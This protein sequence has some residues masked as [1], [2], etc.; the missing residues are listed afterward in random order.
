MLAGLTPA[1]MPCTSSRQDPALYWSSHATL[2]ARIA[3]AAIVAEPTDLVEMRASGLDLSR[4]TALSPSDVPLGAKPGDALPSIETI[5]LLQHS[6]GTT[7][8]KKG[9]KLS[10][11]AI[12]RQLESYGS[13]LAL[14]PGDRFVSWLPLYH[15]M[16]LIACWITP[17]YFGVP[18]VHIDPFEWLGRPELLLVLIERYNGT[19][20]WLPNFAFEHLARVAAPVAGSVRL[21][22]MRAFIDCSE[23][24]RAETFDRFAAAF[25]AS[26]VQPYMLQ[27][28]YAMAETVFAVTQTRLD[29]PV[30]RIFIRRTAV[31]AGQRVEVSACPGDGLSPMLSTGKPIA[32]AAVEVLNSDGAR[33]PEGH[34]GEIAVRA[35]FL[36]SGY[37]HEPERTA[38]RLRDGLYLTNDQGF[39]HEGEL[40]ILGRIDDVIIVNGKNVYAHDVEAVVAAVPGVKAGRGV[41]LGLYDEAVGSEALVV[42][43]E[44]AETVAGP[45][46]D[47]RRAISAAV[48]ATIGVKPVDIRLVEPDWLVK[49]TSGKVSR[50]ENLR[51]YVV[52]FR[53]PR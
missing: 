18:V 53:T 35:S 40:F 11:A 41:A 51:K 38:A 39:L 17:V 25:A 47:V 6:S 36:F 5:A 9:V 33:L 44:R 30:R 42:V 32:G 27:C 52:Q 10:Y 50:S 26:G 45:D 12:L 16:G 2:M 19:H 29:T 34:V 7:G 28:C 15:D 48:F 43:A 21:E 31:A 49:T 37:N 1:F 8:L 3:P 22:S 20:A 46:I 14:R 24:C 4:V 13:A 23:P